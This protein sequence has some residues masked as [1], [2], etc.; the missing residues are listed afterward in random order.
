MQEKHSEYV[1]SA[2]LLQR[3]LSTLLIVVQ[4]AGGVLLSAQATVRSVHLC[5]KPGK[6]LGELFVL[7]SKLYPQLAH[8]GLVR[9]DLRGGPLL[10]ELQ[11]SRQLVSCGFTETQR[12]QVLILLLR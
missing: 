5:A 11:G 4:V 6:L 7:S 8:A 10:G 3:E 2:D 9:G 12:S 1:W